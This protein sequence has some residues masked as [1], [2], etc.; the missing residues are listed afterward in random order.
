MWNIFHPNYF[1]SE[2]MR[3]NK[4]YAVFILSLTV[5][6]AS[7]QE[8]PLTITLGNIKTELKNS[9]L[10]LGI[11]YLVSLDSAY[12]EQ[13]IL[14][15]GKKSLFQI[16][17]EFNVQTGTSDAFSAI[18][19]KITGVALL[20]QTIKIDGI[21]TPDTKKLFHTFPLSA[22]IETNNN[23]DYVNAICEA[24]YVPWYQA[25]F[26]NKVPA[27]L[28]KTKLGIFLQGGY[29]FNLDITDS[30]NKSGG[31]ADQS[32]EPIDKAILRAK[33]SFGIN[34]QELLNLLFLKIGLAG[35]ANGWYD[36]LN[37]TTYFSLEGK[38]RFFVG[39]N[40]YFDFVYQKGSG[41]PNFNKG[42]QYGINL[43]VG[44]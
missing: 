15:T 34:T 10:N 11:Q 23:F 40:R 41:A 22:G 28:K 5:S 8:K 29:K 19:A 13:D 1:N 18:D 36:I 30:V 16:S 3:I 44:F 25:V 6:L 43:T 31:G 42:D 39:K 12:K 14:F 33:G 21:I 2:I 27:W 20:F 4:L 17:P 7:A 9:A 32:K 38:F 37:R 35:D 24:G 26:M